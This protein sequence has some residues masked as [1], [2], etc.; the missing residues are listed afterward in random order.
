[1]S[2]A[3]DLIRNEVSGLHIYSMNR[4]E[5]VKRILQELSYPR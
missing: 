1:M 3:E 2:Q 4:S 5:P